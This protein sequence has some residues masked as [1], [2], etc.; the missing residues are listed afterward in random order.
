MPRAPT[1]C[2]WRMRWRRKAR[3]RTVTACG[4]PIAR[5]SATGWRPSSADYPMWSARWRRNG[6]FCAHAGRLCA[7]TG[8]NGSARNPYGT[9]RNTPAI[10][11]GRTPPAR[12]CPTGCWWWSVR[13]TLRFMRTAFYLHWFRFYK[14][15]W[16]SVSGRLPPWMG[17][18]QQ[19]L[20]SA[21]TSGTETGTS[22]RGRALVGSARLP[23]TER[24]TARSRPFSHC[25][26]G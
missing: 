15:L 18:L 20:K 12:S 22:R 2:G 11:P 26:K 9:W 17:R 7:S 5:S 25:V 19:P 3:T 6:A 24:G 1:L 14:I 4:S 8:L 16:K 10:S 13:T 23:L 21:G